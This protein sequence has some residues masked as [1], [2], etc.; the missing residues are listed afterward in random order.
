MKQA[1]IYL[2]VLF[3]FREYP[4][5]QKVFFLEWSLSFIPS[6]KF[7]LASYFSLI[8]HILTFETSN[9]AEFPPTFHN[10]NIDNFLQPH[11]FSII[12]FL[13]SDLSSSESEEELSSPSY[14]SFLHFD[15]KPVYSDVVKKQ[16]VSVVY[17]IWIRQ[18]NVCHEIIIEI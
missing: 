6:K 7:D 17:C 16:M 11:I 4:Y 13:T 18:C 1:I 8:V 14:A 2:I 9:P 10:V 3:C 5:P 15:Q 12:V